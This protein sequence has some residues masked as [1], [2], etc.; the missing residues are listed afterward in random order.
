MKCNVALRSYQSRRIKWKKERR[1]H[2]VLWQVSPVG[3]NYNSSLLEHVSDLALKGLLCLCGVLVA[4]A[5]LP[6]EQPAHM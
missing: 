2:S 5:E 6:S 4:S 3:S 1:N